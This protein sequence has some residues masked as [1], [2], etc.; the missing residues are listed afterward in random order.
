LPLIAITREM[1]SLG[2]DVAEGLSQA[3]G[4]PVAYHE[5]IDHL[6]DRMRVRKS[7]VERLLDG[8]AGLLE[9]LSADKTSLS[10]FSADEII[11]LAVQGRGAV[12]RGWGATHLLRKV[13]HAVCLRVC[14]PLEVRTQRM[15]QRLGTD[16]LEKVSGEIRDNDEAHGAIMRRHFSL[17]W[18]DPAHYD[19][20][21]NTER[22]NVAECVDKVAA[23]VKSAAFTETEASRGRLEDLALTWRVRA[24]LRV[25]P[26]TR[27]LRIVV[28]AERGRVTL[29][30]VVERDAQRTAASEVAAAVAGVR[31]LDDKLRATDQLRSRFN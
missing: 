27:E 26:L 23:L 28:T 31:A 30:G 25:S 12:V 3:L 4:I 17:D 2:K 21:F 7:H 14:A 10:I 13:P 8:R 11:N 16:E 20:V 6:A 29:D 1:G 19:V 9:R 15:M 18:T 5:I 22:V 24:A